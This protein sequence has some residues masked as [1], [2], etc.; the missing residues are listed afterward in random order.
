MRVY[1]ELYIVLA[2]LT[3]AQHRNGM[4]KQHS[5]LNTYCIVRVDFGFVSYTDG[6]ESPPGLLTPSE[7]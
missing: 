1:I 4:L 3:S 6:G 2:Q 5:V 7:E